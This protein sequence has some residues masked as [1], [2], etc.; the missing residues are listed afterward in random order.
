V[1]LVFFA[2]GGNQVIQPRMPV[3]PIP[4]PTKPG[5]TKASDVMPN[6]PPRMVEPTRGLS[7]SIPQLPHFR[8]TSIRPKSCL[9]RVRAWTHRERPSGHAFL[10]CKTTVGPGRSRADAP[11]RPTAATAQTRPQERIE[12]GQWGSQVRRQP[13]RRGRAFSH[14]ATHQKSSA[15]LLR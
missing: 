7:P 8:R 14:S 9:S 3:P 2:Q 4:R 15:S 12:R 1:V 5:A 10:L 11:E 6:D 13:R